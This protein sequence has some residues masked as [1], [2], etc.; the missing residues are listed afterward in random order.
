MIVKF[1]HSLTL[2]VSQEKT[3]EFDVAKNK[4][5]LQIKKMKYDKNI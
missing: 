5:K 1:F 3:D 4:F 2:A